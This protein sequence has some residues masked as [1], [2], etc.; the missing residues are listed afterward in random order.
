MR[1]GV[2]SSALI[3]RLCLDKGGKEAAVDEEWD[4]ID[5]CLSTMNWERDRQIHAYRVER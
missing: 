2:E 3:E 4:W 5:K 1:S